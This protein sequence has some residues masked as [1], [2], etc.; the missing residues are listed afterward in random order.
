L[1]RRRHLQV[2]LQGAFSTASAVSEVSGRG[3]GMDV[4]RNNIELIGGTV[5]L[6]LTSPA[7]TTFT[8]KIPLTLAIMATLIVEASGH[9]FAIPQHSVIELVRTGNASG[10][11][12]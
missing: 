11:N 9:R 8:L 10:H 4:V 7:G 5:E 2:Y 3:V 1:K 6:K 12:V